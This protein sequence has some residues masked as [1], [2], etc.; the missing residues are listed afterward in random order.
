[1]KN[2]SIFQ[3][4]WNFFPQISSF[5]LSKK[6]RI[7]H[8]FGLSNH[9]SKT[10][11]L[12]DFLFRTKPQNAVFITDKKSDI[13]EY[14]EL[15]QMFFRHESETQQWETFSFSFSQDPKEEQ[16]RVFELLSRTQNH[17]KTLFLLSEEESQKLFPNPKDWSSREY[18]LKTGEKF[19]LSDFFEAM[20]QLG[21]TA[22]LD[23]N[24]DKGEFLRM[25]DEIFI[26]PIG[27]AYPFTIE[28]GFDEVGKIVSR[29]EEH[30]K[31]SIFPL[32]VKWRQTPLV[33]LFTEKDIAIYDDYERDNEDLPPFSGKIVDLSSFPK[34]E[35]EPLHLRFLSVLKFYTLTDFLNDLREKIR[36]EWKMVITTKRFEELIAIFQE[37][38]IPFTQYGDVSANILVMDGKDLEIVPPSFQNPIDKIAFLTDREIF[39]IKTSS[40]KVA[41]NSELIEFLTSLKVGDYIVHL[42]H[43]IGRFLGISEQKISDITRE[44]LEI[45][46]LQNDKL[47]VP[48][49]H[50]D[51][52]SR[53]IA[54][55]DK[56]PR[57]T[58]LGSTEWKTVQKKVK[59]ETEKIA[60]E[61]LKMY[62]ERA[63]AKAFQCKTDD[64]RMHQFE[65]NFKYFPT[66]GQVAAIRDIKKDMES[67]TPMDRLVCG[68]VGFGKTEVAMRAAFK[69]VENGLQVAVI[70]P[71][72]ILVDQHYQNFKKRMEGFDIR[73][74]MLS[75][76]RTAQEQ[77]KILEDLKKGKIDIIIGTHRLISSDVGFYNLGLLIIDEE[78]RF[79]VKQKEKLKDLRKEVHIL[80]MTA[81]PI[82]RTLNLALHKLREISTIT[83]PPPGRLPI[84]TEV[85]KYSDRLIRDAI[86][87]EVE[88]GG[89]VY[90]LHNRVETIEAIAEKLRHL[91]PEARFGVAHGQLKAEDLE[92]KIYA[93]KNQEFDVLVSSTII[94]NGI[95]LANANTMIINKAEAFGL[96]QL[97]QLRGRIGRSSRQAFAYLMYHAQRLSLDA[98]KRLRAIVEASELGSG[99]Q[100]SM[101]DLEISGAGDVLGV[102]Q[103]GSVNMVGVSHFL[104]LLKQTITELEQGGEKEEEI[105]QDV[106]LELPMDAYIPSFF[107]S[108]AKEKI[109]TYQ[110]LAS[111]TTPG[112]LKDLAEEL[113]EEYGKLPKEV[114]NLLQ[115]LEIKVHARTANL[116]GIS[117]V[118]EAVQLSLSKKV[119]AHEIMNL[120]QYQKFWTI[121][122]ES[123]RASLKQLGFNWQETLL[124]A[125][126]LLE[127]KRKKEG[128]KGKKSD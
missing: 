103:H 107:I 44:Y 108:D 92:K 125:L 2:L 76:F 38:N 75:R 71:I 55:E 19:R 59:K 10:F 64:D 42:D 58:R 123:L 83:T 61:L 69:A 97:Y 18:V 67:T 12:A 48:I 89:Q 116:K 13:Y 87:K 102:S 39:H 93:F 9:S 57:L 105:I 111:I 29:G 66:P 32:A 21:Y 35:D 84:V 100:L 99:F 47:F 37:E 117:C 91:V 26:F 11:F 25:G 43:G 119:T 90:F 78:Q 96:S 50:S 7:L 45:Q 53:Y 33:D 20:D 118:G 52:V 72:T 60:K 41:K 127:P 49:E 27:E 85:R 124:D 82:P 74:E 65:E 3:D 22:G 17:K 56:V 54:D 77:K 8:A 68:D 34:E 126:R 98:K 40:K 14:E 104:R 30:Q 95:D 110:K 51:K 121:S 109:L 16:K 46:Y 79:G 114:K 63:K 4:I 31:I 101:R 88:R 5:S 62:A 120:L 94:E 70:A 73:I 128:K 15:F 36:S 1:M 122:G 80:T 115:V 81:T 112:M 23:R 86:V 6:K 113:E 24:V 106:S 28:I